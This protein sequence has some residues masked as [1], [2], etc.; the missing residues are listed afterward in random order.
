MCFCF[1][2]RLPQCERDFI[3]AHYD[4]RLKMGERWESYLCAGAAEE[5]I[6]KYRAEE[7]VGDAILQRQSRLRKSK[8]KMQSEKKDELG[9][10][11]PD[12][13]VVKKLED[14]INQME[15]E[16]HRHQERLNNQGQTAR[17]AAAN[18]EECVLLRN[19]HD[20]HGRT[21]AWIYDQGRCADYGGCCARNCGCCEKPLR[22]YIRPTSGGR[23]KLIE[24]RGH[25]TAECACCIRSQGYYKPHERLPPTAFTNK[26][27]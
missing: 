12:E 2:P 15:I 13:A 20:R 19:H 9:K 25:C 10:G 7:S 14:E 21:Y 3:N 11:L 6:P 16:Y 22:K 1:G 24:V 8:L 18:A 4:I 27:C 26:D 23:K 17:G 5:W